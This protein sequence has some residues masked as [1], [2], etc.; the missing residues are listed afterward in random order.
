MPD[1]RAPREILE[2]LVGFDTTSAKSNLPL[3]HWVRDWLAEL[4]VESTLVPD[5]TGTKAALFAQV[6]PNV[7]GGVVLS[8]H[9]DC[10][11]VADQ[12]WSSDP[13]TLVER[14]GRLF[15][16]G[17]SD[18]KGFDALALAAVPRALEAGLKRPLQIALSYDEE[19]G[20]R[21]APPM[22]AAMREALPP[23]E[24]VI[25]GEPTLM[26]TVTA[27]KGIVGLITRVRGFEVHSSLCHTGVSAVAA[28][29]RLAAWLDARMAENAARAP[30][31]P[32]AA[33]YAPPWTTLHV[34]R[35]E[36]GTAHNITAGHAWFS[37]D[38]RVAPPETTDAWVARYREEAA[39]LE[40][41]LRRIRPEARIE[42]EERA[43]VPPCRREPAGLAGDGAAERLVRALTGDN[44]DNVV[45]Y[46]TEAGQFQDAG[47]SA[48]ICG[49][50]SIEQAHQPDEFI[51]VSELEAGEAFMHRLVDR[52]AA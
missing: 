51:A 10:V 2:T 46:A 12:A 32:E 43:T 18:M 34:G 48:A 33:A 41:E 15:G 42:I 52:L 40:A 7:P 13:F 19:V 14:D 26:R 35:F 50:G 24:A 49:P 9:T 44:S 3:I 30:A 22:I 28:G 45:A 37:T 39:R 31:S 11:P 23:A 4:G 21:G 16:R 8:G 38:I 6:G 25:V 27:H 29:A 17:T 36:G 5:E 1:A 20:C 47:Y